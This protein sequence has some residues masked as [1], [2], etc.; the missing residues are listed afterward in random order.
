MWLYAIWLPPGVKM[1]FFEIRLQIISRRKPQ[2]NINKSLFHYHM[3]SS[4]YNIIL[5]DLSPWKNVDQ[6]AVMHCFPFCFH[7]W[8]V[9]A[10]L[11]FL[12]TCFR[13]NCLIHKDIS[14]Q[15]EATLTY[16]IFCPKLPFRFKR[17]SPVYD[18][19]NMSMN[20]YEC[21][22]CPGC[23]QRRSCGVVTF[24]FRHVHAAS[25]IWLRYRQLV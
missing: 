15:Q 18:Y 7:D 3:T 20:L 8:P 1:C 9:F 24:L 16:D 19:L 6:T 2:S 21:D 10:V 17:W 23:W 14:T 13:L 4:N 5:P 22:S 11:F 25:V 12:F